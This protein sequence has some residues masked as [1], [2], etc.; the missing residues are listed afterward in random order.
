M[1]Q[2]SAVAMRKLREWAGRRHVMETSFEISA[3]PRLA[4]LC[5]AA[6]LAER[7]DARWSFKPGLEGFPLIGLKAR[8]VLQLECQRCLAPLSWPIEVDCRLTAVGGENEIREVASPYDTVVAGHE[9]LSLGK[10]L[11]DEILTSLPMAPAHSQ[12]A[13]VR[14]ARPEVARGASRPLA[15]LGALMRQARD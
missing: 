4:E 2:N 15:G 6:G 10:I 1:V 8:G 13:A 14:E 9:G 7:I 3:S 11:E 12:C 5:R